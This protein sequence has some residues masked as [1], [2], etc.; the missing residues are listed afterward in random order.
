MDRDELN[1]LIEERALLKTE[2][3]IRQNEKL[4]A[5]VK[6]WRLYSIIAGLTTVAIYVLYLIR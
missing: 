3:L 4:K 1:K 6:T 5:E 2:N